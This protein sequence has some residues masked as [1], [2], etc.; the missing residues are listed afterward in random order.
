MHADQLSSSPLTNMGLFVVLFSALLLRGFCRG[1]PTT[2]TPPSGTCWVMGSLYYTFD[3]H[4]YTFTGNCTYTFAKNCHVDETLP[5]FEVATKNLNEGSVQ[6]PSVETVTVNVYGINIEI[7]RNEYGIVRVNYHKWLL[8]LNLNNGQVKLSLKGLYVVMETDFGLIVQYDWDQYLVV[9]LPG[10]FSGSVCGLC[11]NFN[12]KKEDDLTTPSGSEAS[13]MSELGQS[14][15]VPGTDANCQ[16]GCGDDCASCPLGYVQKLEKHIFCSALIQNYQELLGC[17]P[18]IDSNLL[19]S[20]CMLDL[21]RGET[22]N[23]YLCTT[24]QGFADVCQRAG[25]KVGSSWRTP[26][27]CPTPKCPE[28]S[29]Y[30]FC[31]NGCPATC[32]D[33]NPPTKCNFTCVETCVC[34]EGFVLSG[35]KC[36]PKDQCGC[37]YEGFYV[38]AGASFWGDETC[39][40]RITCSTGGSLSS[41]ETSCPAG[42]QCRVVEGIRGCNP[43]NEA[44]CMVSGDPHFVT[45][46]GERFNFQGTCSYEMAGVSSNQTDMEHFSVI[47][48]NNGQDKK[49]G[50]V[51]K[52]VEVQVNGNTIIISKDDPGAVVVNGLRSNLPMTLNSNK[53]HLYMSGW[54]AVI[55]MDSGV[56]VYYDW[57]SVAFVTVPSTYMGAMQGLCGNYNLNPKDDMQMKDGKQATSSE[58]LGQSWKVATI[59][60]CVDGCSGPCPG[61]NSTQK[62][63]YNSNSYCGLISDPAGPFRDCQ[64]KVDPAGFLND[65]VYDVC[66]YQGGQ[67]MQCKTLTAY[68]AACQLQGATVYSWRS[69]EF[70]AAQCPSKSQYELCSSGCPRSCQKDCG[71]QCM[72]GCVCDEGYLMSGGECVPANQCGC[73]YE[74]Q[75]YQQGQVFY[76]DAL[77]QNE[78]TCNGTVTC[79]QS[80][81]GQF[82]TCGVNNYVRSC[83]PS[84]KGLCTISGDPHYN[85]F[86][87]TTYNFQGTCTYI[88]AEGCHLNGTELTPFS[89]AVEN[90]KW[91]GLSFNPK[92]SV[93]KLVAVEVHGT[94]LILRKNDINM[95]WVNG[96]L[97]HLP[98]NLNNGAVK[99]YQEGQNDI[100]VT[101]FGLR[102]TYDLVYHV[103]ITVPGTYSGRTC[104]LCGNFNNDKADEFQLQDGTITKDIQSFGAVWKVPVIGAVCEDGCIGDQC[105]VC[106]ES[107]KAVIEA[108]CAVIS[109]PNGPFAACQGIIDPSSYFRDCVYDVCI[110]ENDPI[111]LC[112]SISAY[113]LDC[114]DFGAKIGNWRNA[115]FC[116]L[117][118]SPGSHYDTCV[119]PCTASCPGLVDTLTC[120]TTCVEGCACDKD[121]YYNG[122]GCVPSDQCS[123]YYNGHTYKVGETVIT[124]DCHRMHTCHA[125]GIVVSKNMTCDPDQSCLVKGGV[126]SCQ[127]QHCF[128]DANG[129]LNQFNGEGGTITEPGS[130]E[131]IQNCDVSQTTD[132][133]RVVVKLE[134]CT[135]GF[136]TILAV[137]VFF[138]DMTISVNSKHDIWING[139]ELTQTPFTKSDVN[140]VVSDNTVII[141]S[142]STIHVSFSSTNELAISV[143]DVVADVLCGACGTIRPTIIELL[144]LNIGKWKAPDFSGC[145]I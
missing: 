133:F 16:N 30:E 95:V 45:F 14:W 134:T 61:C 44:T 53:L 136:N 52:V 124:D 107:K 49:I 130:Y 109:D 86:D 67:N 128:L 6:V 73:T 143:S 65:C 23:T 96:I 8:P 71:T 47:L 59:P 11:G 60:G 3:G 50:S 135:P 36:V 80:S 119:L 94:V 39:T 129:T 34:K 99:V 66:L 87:N 137:Y 46:D 138:N 10:S 58:E 111:M 145:D 127:L 40:K 79:K 91:Y 69:A 81:C 76:P 64:A 98:L 77:C 62:D 57:N 5:A 25:A 120:T 43:V 37:T 27:Q 104:G 54:F 103:T 29:N 4:D 20:N 126:M 92:V 28:N 106:D 78:C 140:V 113:M 123:C 118:C 38:E 1:G 41:S 2:T 26:T 139:R 72:E 105:P 88:A 112:H 13:S 116:P 33:L 22:V 31:G 117:P 42:Q 75:Y 102:V 93:T 24:L 122:T 19:R 51:V 9:T 63:T 48:Q 70:C 84:R 97:T 131:I 108:E 101:D 121:F 74:G 114:Q 7:V 21:C 68:T 18:D 141:D 82:E 12:N 15:M 144:A 110:S 55:E 142:T 100:I 17:L 32:A 85:T 35:T 89:V 56:K 90:E 115:T 83:Q 125:S 132:W